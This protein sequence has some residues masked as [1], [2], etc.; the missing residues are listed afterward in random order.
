MD[1]A[2]LQLS[3]RI[4]RLSHT[5]TQSQ[6]TKRY[7]LC[8]LTNPHTNRSTNLA[9]IAH[10]IVVER[11]HKLQSGCT[12]WKVRGKLGEEFKHSTLV[13]SPLGWLLLLVVV[14]VV[15]LFC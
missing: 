3:S 9:L 10:G 12:E 5:D 13:R 7:D 6:T 14:V 4:Y 2:G 11:G 8:R 1:T 15:V